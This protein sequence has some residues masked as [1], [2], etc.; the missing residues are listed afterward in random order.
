M[1]T[2][3]DDVLF[4]SGLGTAAQIDRLYRAAFD[5]APDDDGPGYWIAQHK[6]GMGMHDIAPRFL[7]SP[8]FQSRYGPD[9]GDTAFVNGLYHN[10]LHRDGDA[11]GGIA[12]HLDHLAHRMARADVLLAFSNS[13]ENQATTVGLVGH[14]QAD[15][16][17]G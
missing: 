9:L 5:R 11:G 6:D 3:S 13:P 17:Y 16:P 10:V 8:E 2:Q 7:L 12:Y 4:A 1:F 15:M 14:A